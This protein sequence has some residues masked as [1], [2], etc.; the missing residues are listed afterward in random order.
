MEI[1]N[2]LVRREARFQGLDLRA[3]LRSDH[4]RWRVAQHGADLRSEVDR[5]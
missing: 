3:Q 4:A 1:E 2:G 5:R